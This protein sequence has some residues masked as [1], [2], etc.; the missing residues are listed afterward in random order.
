MGRHAVDT[1]EQRE[2]VGAR[3]VERDEQEV[4]AGRLV[5]SAAA[6]AE[7]QDQQCNEAAP[8]AMRSRGI[9][10]ERVSAEQAA[11]VPR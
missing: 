10:D 8:E 3:R 1:A 9:Q 2:R 4:P 5:G 11:S 7:G 6:A